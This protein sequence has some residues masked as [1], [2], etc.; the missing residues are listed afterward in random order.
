MASPNTP[1]THPCSPV[2]VHVNNPRWGATQ[3]VAKVYMD[4]AR[5]S[6]FQTIHFPFLLLFYYQRVVYLQWFERNFRLSELFRN[7][8]TSFT[9]QFLK[10]VYYTNNN[11]T[12]QNI[13]KM[14]STSSC[15]LDWIENPLAF[16]CQWSNSDFAW[17]NIASCQSESS[18]FGACLASNRSA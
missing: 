5:W 17:N 9:E 1:K 13:T 16:K 10:K 6:N 18:V 11:N 15:H 2:L 12:L 3:I 14:M 4:R 7:H 8:L